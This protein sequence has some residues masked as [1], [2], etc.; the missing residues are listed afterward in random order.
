M[1]VS[2]KFYIIVM[3]HWQEM[4]TADSI[5]TD[6]GPIGREEALK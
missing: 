6:H 4:F 5:K 2:I 3:K 1:E